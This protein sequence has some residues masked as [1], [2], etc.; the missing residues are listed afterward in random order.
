MTSQ[1]VEWILGN[2]LAPLVVG[3]FLIS[4]NVQSQIKKTLSDMSKKPLKI[5]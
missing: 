4:S 1:I 2:L 3:V 5:Y